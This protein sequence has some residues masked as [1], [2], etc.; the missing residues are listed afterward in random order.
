MIIKDSIVKKMA[1]MNI[2]GQS[3]S[4]WKIKNQEQQ[5]IQISIKSTSSGI[6]IAKIK[7]LEGELSKKIIVR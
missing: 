5:N 3:I 1:L 7:T 6:Y 2:F 4:P